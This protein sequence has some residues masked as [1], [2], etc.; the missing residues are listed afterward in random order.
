MPPLTPTGANVTVTN[1]AGTSYTLRPAPFISISSSPLRNKNAFFGIRYN[2]ALSGTIISGSP[3]NGDMNSSEV[4][5]QD[6]ITTQKNLTAFFSGDGTAIQKLEITPGGNAAAITFYVRFESISFEE[7]N[8]VQTCKYTINLVSEV[9]NSRG[10]IPEDLLE[11]F[12]ENWSFDIDTNHTYTDDSGNNPLSSRSFIA[13]RTITATGR[14]SPTRS[15]IQ[16][17][18]DAQSDVVSGD[19]PYDKPAWMQAMVYIENYAD[20]EATT[21]ATKITEILS[22]DRSRL[23]SFLGASYQQYNHA[24]TSSIDKSAGTVTITD[25]WVLAPSDTM[26][27]ENYTL[28]VSSSLDNPYVKVS[29]QGSI[30]GLAGP[31]FPDDQ[32]AANVLANSPYGNALTHYNSIS[33]TLEYG[34]SCAIFRRVANAVSTFDNM[35]I[36]P[37]PLSMSDGRNE[38]T[39]EITYTVEFDNR[40]TNYFTD[41][42]FENISV[43]DTY[44]GDVFA[45]IPVLGRPVGPILQFTFGRTEY[46]RD[47]TIELVLNHTQIGTGTGRGS[48]LLT[49]PSIRQP[50]AGELISLIAL[51]S[52]ANEPGIRKYFLSP[53]TESWNP[54][55]GRY[56]LSLG[57]TYEL[58]E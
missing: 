14:N 11:D 1:V 54:K 15:L 25:T 23:G 56:T 27:L 12:S 34:N 3:T 36:N 49:K 16:S 37:K 41:V 42:L 18:Q 19:Q 33:N 2:I 30:K 9:E 40:P 22:H 48:Y 50:N 47:I 43:N 13:T 32:F 7:G 4:A 46:R 51:L 20:P 17:A 28:S 44:P 21:N 53:P 35:T 8:Y 58:S 29:I 24:R 38:I 6:I 45:I 39:G 10:E 31:S 5:L 57:W 52:P 55:D 26:A